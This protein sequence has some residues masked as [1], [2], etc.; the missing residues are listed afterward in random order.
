MKQQNILLVT[1]LS[2]TA[3]W[4]CDS[5]SDD[6]ESVH[7]Q[8]GVYEGV[9]WAN[10]TS[11]SGAQVVVQEGVDPQLTLWDEREHQV[12]Y[13]GALSDGQIDFAAASVSCEM[14][15]QEL[16]CSNGNGSSALS[17]VTL[18]S[19]DISNYEGTYQARYSDAL[20]QMS[21]DQQGSLSLS[22]SSCNSE[23]SLVTSATVENLVMMQ[24]TDEQCIETGTLNIITLEVDNDSLVSINVQTDSDQFPQVW[25][26]L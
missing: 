4:G 20:Y 9:I 6:N 22:G 24:L 11:P 23:G 10:D 26:K 16:I 15:D 13:L 18:E 1:L 25:I 12:S 14:S 19:D 2:L 7:V 3:L 21:I 5:D 17:P 8:S